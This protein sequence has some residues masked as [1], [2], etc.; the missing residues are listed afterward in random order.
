MHFFTTLSYL[1]II[2]F[3]VYVPITTRVSS[4]RLFFH[5][6]HPHFSHT[7]LSFTL[8]CQ[9]KQER[10][11]QHIFWTS[12]STPLQPHPIVMSERAMLLFPHIQF[13]AG[14]VYLPICILTNLLTYYSPSGTLCNDDD[15]KLPS[16]PFHA[17]IFLPAVLSLTC[18]ILP[19]N[20]S[21]TVFSP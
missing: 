9:I 19:L 17:N 2:F 16:I 13:C 20:N 6:N 11:P 15:R 12:S 14:G 5:L 21:S 1:L 18:H 3:Y 10:I 7:L 4:L 8:C